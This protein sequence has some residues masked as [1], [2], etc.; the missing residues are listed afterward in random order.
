MSPF[1]RS[2]KGPPR[3][4]MKKT[5]VF[6]SFLI[7]FGV[8]HSALH[9]GDSDPSFEVEREQE[10][11]IQFDTDASEARISAVVDRLRSKG[12]GTEYF[13][14]VRVGAVDLPAHAVQ[15]ILQAYPEVI[16]QITP[17]RSMAV[18]GIHL[19]RNRSRRSLQR[20][21]IASD[22]SSLK[23][24][25]ELVVNVLEQMPDRFRGGTLGLVTT[26][27]VGGNGRDLIASVL[28]TLSRRGIPS[29]FIAGRALKEV[30]FMD[31]LER[32]DYDN[33]REFE[34]FQRY[35]TSLSSARDRT[36]D[37]VLS[38]L[39]GHTAQEKA[40]E[41]S[42]RS[43]SPESVSGIPVMLH[44]RT[45]CMIR[46]S[47]VYVMADEPA[48]NRVRSRSGQHSMGKNNLRKLMEEATL[49]A[50]LVMPSTDSGDR[51]SNRFIQNAYQ[52][53]H[54]A[55]TI[56]ERRRNRYKRANELTLQHKRSM[57][58]APGV[59]KP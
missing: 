11:L 15:S 53:L 44:A 25:V 30:D 24:A 28:K 9:A 1:Q 5:A 36:G 48:F 33:N 52:L 34:R 40:D 38:N 6:L 35:M 20:T 32:P 29:V 21:R 39:I 2:F 16:D 59:R 43:D 27:P 46:S 51:N 10:Y 41:A 17:N 58:P 37:T 13:G 23:G 49:T 47:D 8:G 55:R 14:T 54:S 57:F 50:F 42:E 7:L 12:D 31:V 4:R 19:K 45:G 22:A 18:Q 26:E 3:S 56:Q